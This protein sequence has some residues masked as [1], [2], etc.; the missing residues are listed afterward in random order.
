MNILPG[1]HTKTHCVIY[2]EVILPRCDGWA[3]SII[4]WGAATAVMPVPIPMMILAA[5]NMPRFCEAHCRAEPIVTSA[6]PRE[7]GRRRPKASQ[8]FQEKMTEMRTP[9]LIALT[10]VPRFAPL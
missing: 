7:I 8:S 1:L 5:M 10:R 4:S 3:A 2:R 9:M 6:V